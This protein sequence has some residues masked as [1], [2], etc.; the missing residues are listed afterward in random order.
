MAK[1][2]RYTATFSDGAVITRNSHREYQAAWRA[3][4]TE[5]EVAQGQTERRT[6]TVTGFSRTPALA[7]RAA[8]TETRPA[9]FRGCDVQTEVAPAVVQA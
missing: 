1:P 2:I 4:V 3:I 7:V 6:W 8:A 9:L 5:R